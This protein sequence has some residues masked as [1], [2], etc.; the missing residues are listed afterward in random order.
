MANYERT[1]HLTEP[2]VVDCAFCEG[3][4]IEA[5]DEVVR[6][7]GWV[8]L[9]NAADSIPERRIVVRVALPSVVARALLRDLRKSLAKGG[10]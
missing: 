5:R 2:K 4:Y 9:Q 6:L 10:H 7:V 8:D 1:P 3:V